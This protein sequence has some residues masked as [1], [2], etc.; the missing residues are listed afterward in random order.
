MQPSASTGTPSIAPASLLEAVLAIDL[1]LERRTL[2]PEAHPLVRGSRDAY[3]RAWRTAQQVVGAIH[4]WVGPG[5]I[6]WGPSDAQTMVGPRFEAVGRVLHAM[7]VASISVA[8]DASGDEVLELLDL[9]HALRNDPRPFDTIRRWE[10]QSENRRVHVAV[11][12]VDGLEYSDNRPRTPT[13]EVWAGFVQY[14]D[15]TE[16]D[17]ES[18]AKALTEMIEDQG[19]LGLGA[20][21]NSIMESLDNVPPG[22]ARD[23]SLRMV[24]MLAALPDSLRGDILRIGSPASAAMLAKLVRPL[25]P[26]DAVGA[27][28][29]VGSST[30]EIPKATASILSNILRCLPEGEQVVHDV[31]GAPDEGALDVAEVAEALQTVL[32]KRATQDFNP[33][34]Y[35]ARLDELVRQENLS[36][37]RSSHRA[38]AFENTTVV[39]TQLGGIAALTLADALPDEVAANV[40]AID[41]ALP[42]L[43]DS[44]RL[45]LL[46]VAANSILLQCP[47]DCDPLQALTKHLSAN[48]SRLIALGTAQESRKNELRSVLA[49]VSPDAVAKEA[50]R[51]IME[52]NRRDDGHSLRA[53]LMDLDGPVLAAALSSAVEKA[54]EK[55]VRV[56]LLLRDARS[57]EVRALL[58]R[59]KAHANHHIRLSALTVAVDRDGAARQLVSLQRSLFDPDPE[60]RRWALQRLASSPTES[61]EVTTTLQDLLALGGA[62]LSEEISLRLAGLLFRRGAEGARL[63][64]VAVETM[65]KKRNRRSAALARKLVAMLEEYRA[66]PEVE[67]VLGRWR[68]SLANLLGR[69]PSWMT[70]KDRG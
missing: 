40:A 22:A 17:P 20:L 53:V 34:D 6:G 36:V 57:T 8:A 31:L 1:A 35:Q 33:A 32:E 46:A 16:G 51:L 12:D 68:W 44:E 24:R 65:R 60:I 2:Y 63:V 64:A 29:L 18:L 66:D 55:T 11:L 19:P 7:H 28:L 62:K 26:R 59:W 58:D 10:Q 38:E 27:L 5:R 37:D 21:R 49:L 25:S 45:D 42:A 39:A 56:R 43:L 30:T 50:L 67:R 69:L 3:V 70:G 13:G 52:G 15:G 54:P 41:R 61:E 23:R 14:L 9:I 47:K 48:L 4:L